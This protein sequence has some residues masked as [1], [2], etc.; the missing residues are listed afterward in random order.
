MTTITVCGDLAQ[1]IDRAL[2]VRLPVVARGGERDGGDLVLLGL[3]VEI[4]VDRRVQAAATLVHDVAHGQR[5]ERRG[6]EVHIGVRDLRAVEGVL[7]VGAAGG[8]AARFDTG[9]DH[10]AVDLGAVVVAGV[11]LGL[12]ADGF[13]DGGDRRRALGGVGRDRGQGHGGERAGRQRDEDRTGEGAPHD[14]PVRCRGDGTR[15][16][17]SDQQDGAPI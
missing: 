4:D 10:S 7:H 11:A 12:D 6:S 15:R 9:I 8:A 17:V 13:R 5:R 2:A 14:A 1:Q 3:L 16:A